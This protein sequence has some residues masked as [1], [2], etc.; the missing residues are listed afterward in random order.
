MGKSLLATL[1]LLL[2]PA[3]AAAQSLDPRAYA[4]LPVGLNFL[5]AGYA[6][7]EGELA[8]DGLALQDGRTGVHALPV[9]SVRPRD[10]FG[11][12]GNIAL[13]VPL[14]DLSATGSLDGVTQTRRDVSG[15][16]DPAL[17][18]SVNFYGAPALRPAEFA[19]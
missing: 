17:R 6:Y 11:K 13:V 8:F 5:L 2:A 16:A 9:G 4:N 19:A 10:V 3:L 14:V 18:L 7:S 15:L 1:T 12:S